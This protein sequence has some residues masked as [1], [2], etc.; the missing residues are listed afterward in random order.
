MIELTYKLKA[1]KIY[2]FKKFE[3]QCGVFIKKMIT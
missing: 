3:V 1:L 2:S